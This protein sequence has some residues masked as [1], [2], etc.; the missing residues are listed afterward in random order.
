MSAMDVAFIVVFGSGSIALLVGEWM[1]AREDRARE[2]RYVPK[3]S[4][5]ALDEMHRRSGGGAAMTAE[6]GVRHRAWRAWAL[7]TIRTARPEPCRCVQCA[8]IWKECR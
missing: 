8:A 4:N 1:V 5:Q 2:R 3:A 7:T 6:E